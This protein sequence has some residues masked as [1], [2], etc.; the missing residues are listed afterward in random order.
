MA[1]TTNDLLETLKTADSLDTYLNDNENE[2]VNLDVPAALQQLLEETG[3]T[4]AEALHRAEINDIY[5]YQLFAGSR[6]P[7]RDKLLSLAIGMGA[8]AE[9]IQAL[10]KSTGFAPLYAKNRRDSILLYGIRHGQT[11]MQLNTALY[12]HGEPTL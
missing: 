8:S 1:K 6:K 2:L 4:K 11:V 5:G 10:L 3:L 12:D 7:S 9:R